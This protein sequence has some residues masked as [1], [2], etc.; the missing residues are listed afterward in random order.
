MV[1]AV[2]V[3][4]LIYCCNSV[5]ICNPTEGRSNHTIGQAGRAATAPL[6]YIDDD[7]V[8]YRQ[9]GKKHSLEEARAGL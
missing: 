1:S 9:K 8:I 4:P 7:A 3:H 2:K 6:I 5:I